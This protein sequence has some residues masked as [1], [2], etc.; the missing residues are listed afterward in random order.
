MLKLMQEMLH[1]K[2]TLQSLGEKYISPE[3]MEEY[4][5][6]YDELIERGKQLHPIP[7][8]TAGKRGRVK[9]GRA[10]CLVE[11]MELRK[12]EIFRFLTDFD[13]PY[14]NNEAERSFRLLGIRKNVGIFRNM[15]NAKEFCLIWSYVSTARKHGHSYYKAIYEAFN[16]R[17][18]ELIFPNEEEKNESQDAA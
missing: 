14:T 2:H 7:E 11:R 12:P 13:V 3:V 6:R 9:K 4:S 5:K 18:Y 17:G 15:E 1:K 10:R 8:K 16:D